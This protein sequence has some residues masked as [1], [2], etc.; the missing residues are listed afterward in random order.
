MALA[1]RRLPGS[2]EQD[3]HSVFLPCPVLN[4]SLPLEQHSPCWQP[5]RISRPGSQRTFWEVGGGGRGGKG[6]AQSQCFLWLVKES[7]V[8]LPSISTRY[9]LLPHMWAQGLEADQTR[10]GQKPQG[11]RGGGW[12]GGWKR[13]LSETSGTSCSTRRASE[14]QGCRHP[15]P[16]YSTWCPGDTPAFWHPSVL[17]LRLLL[18]SVHFQ[19]VDP[20]L[21]ALTLLA[22]ARRIPADSAEL[23]EG[24]E[25]WRVEVM[26]PPG[27]GGLPFLATV[28]S[29]GVCCSLR[30]AL[31]PSEPKAGFRKPSAHLTPDQKPLQPLL[32]VGVGVGS[33]CPSPWTLGRQEAGTSAPW[34]LGSL[35]LCQWLSSTWGGP[36]VPAGSQACPPQHSSCP[37]WGR[38]LRSHSF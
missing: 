21:Q 2:P 15:T 7:R 27:T 4:W 23:P 33:L 22:C 36:G 32:R 12:G 28:C 3:S 17:L 29:L 8:G 20:S 6:P 18:P 1:R 13:S 34:G 25:S 26:T 35:C 14:P 5:L 19:V 9:Q 37:F 11:S 16:F 24:Q 31:G 30:C 10:A 38:D